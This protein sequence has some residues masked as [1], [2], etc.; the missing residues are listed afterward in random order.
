VAD[1]FINNSGFTQENITVAGFADTKPIDSNKT[2][3]GRARNR[4]IEVIVDGS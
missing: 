4:R 2:S 1:F 3:S